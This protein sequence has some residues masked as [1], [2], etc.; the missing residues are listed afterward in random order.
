MNDNETFYWQALFPIAAGV[1][2]PLLLYFLALPPFMLAGAV[3]GVTALLLLWHAGAVRANRTPGAVLL[4]RPPWVMLLAAIFLLGVAGAMYILPLNHDSFWW[5]FLVIFLGVIIYGAYLPTALLF[6]VATPQA[7][8]RQ[9]LSFK[10]TLPWAQIDWIYAKRKQVSQSALE[11]IPVA[12]WTEETVF[13]EAGA[14]RRIVVVMRAPLVRANAQP[15]LAA[16][17][18]RATHAIFGF[19]QYPAVAARRSARPDVLPN[20]PADPSPGQFDPAQAAELGRRELVPTGW[21]RFP[22]R[23]RN[24]WQNALSFTVVGLA[25]LGGAA[26]LYLTSVFL[27]ADFVPLPWR[28]EQTTAIL[29]IAQ[30]AV[31]GVVFLVFVRR[32]LWWF[33]PLRHLSDYFFLVTPTGFLEVKGAKAKG[34]AFANLRGVRL[35]GGDF[36]WQLVATLR[37]GKKLELDIGNNY[38]P[39]REVYAY[40]LAGLNASRGSEVGAR[41]DGGLGAALDI[42]VESSG[43]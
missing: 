19:D 34:A 36:G 2:I 32:G 43:G 13:V 12:R 40:V 10:K 18:Q 35:G 9:A 26:Y 25:L 29:L 1:A 7:L 20:A 6:W 28:S 16:I 41:R 33:T 27:L 15:L 5:Y 38:G 42:E 11:V 4:A 17:Q 30:T 8:M 31:L 39:G 23:R 24:A 22:L 37:S 14:K 3:V 21:T